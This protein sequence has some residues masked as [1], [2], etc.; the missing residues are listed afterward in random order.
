MPRPILSELI[1]KHTV[2]RIESI[3]YKHFGL[4]ALLLDPQG[5]PLS[6]GTGIP[7]FCKAINADVQGCRSCRDCRLS[8]GNPPAQEGKAS[9]SPCRAQMVSFTA[10]IT[11]DNTV[12]GYLSGG[13]TLSAPPSES[14]TRA[15]CEKLSLDSNEYAE[16][17]CGGEIPVANDTE[18]Q[19][20]AELFYE[21]AGLMSD[22]AQKNYHSKKSSKRLERSAHAQASF[23]MD[24]NGELQKNMK[25]WIGRVRAALEDEIDKNVINDLLDRSERFLVRI[26]DTV[27][28]AKITSGE[29]EL[30]E[31]EYDVH[32]LMARAAD[33]IQN[34]FAEKPLV[35]CTVA[36]DV[37]ATLLGDSDRL[38]Q[39]ISRLAL[40]LIHTEHPKIKINVSCEVKGYSHIIRIELS[41]AGRYMSGGELKSLNSMIKGRLSLDSYNDPDSISLAGIMLR[42]MSAEFNARSTPTDGTVYT[43]SVP[44]LA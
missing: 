21:L 23:I 18:I 37:P 9:I 43:V 31:T 16:Y 15:I 19:K 32:R 44:Q 24:M 6:K 25:S 13:Q 12:V 3:L 35:E 39:I 33:S 5:A 28:Y 38:F 26:N 22:I 2:L 29:I 7:S 1:D 14:S 4:S 20:T 11:V 42:Q 34:T 40:N 41:N 36:D 27:E 10:P 8:G 17:L 30:N